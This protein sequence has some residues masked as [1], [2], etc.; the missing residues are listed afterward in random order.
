MTPAE[1]LAQHIDL[2]A[3]LNE[4]LDDYL[5][6]HPKK[7]LATTTA[8][9]L[10]RWSHSQT[11]QPEEV[12]SKMQNLKEA[13]VTWIARHLDAA[14]PDSPAVRD[15]ARY[16]DEEAVNRGFRTTEELIRHLDRKFEQGLERAKA[17]Q[18]ARLERIASAAAGPAREALPRVAGRRDS[19]RTRDAHSSA[20]AHDSGGIRP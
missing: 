8:A 18:A 7:I 3:A 20:R 1:H 19:H 2:H 14:D 4:L 13:V 11:V 16:L 9:E 5:V 15:F 12:K 6:H 10:L 17:A